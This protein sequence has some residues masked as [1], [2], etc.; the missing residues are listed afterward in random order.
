MGVCFNRKGT[1]DFVKRAFKAYFEMKLGDQG[2]SWAPYI[3]CKTCFETICVWTN[4]KLKLKFAVPMVWRKPKNH[5]DDCYVLIIWQGSTKPRRNLKY[6]NLKS[7]IKPVCVLSNYMCF[8][9][10]PCLILKKS[11]HF[12]ARS[13]HKLMMTAAA[14]IKSLH[15]LLDNSINPSSMT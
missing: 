14:T 8:F 3:V 6:P 7:A 9:S 11:R 4:G 15:M 12:F 5:F 10:Q 1:S 2:K 13:H